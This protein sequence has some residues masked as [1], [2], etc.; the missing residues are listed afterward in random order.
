MRACGNSDKVTIVAA[1]DRLNKTLQF[2]RIC[3]FLAEV[4]DV[5]SHFV[6]LQAKGQPLELSLILFNRATNEG[7]DLLLLRFIVAMFQCELRRE[8]SVVQQSQRNRA[9]APEQFESIPKSEEH[10][11]VSP[12]EAKTEPFPGPM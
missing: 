11:E 7:N 2:C 10:P 6:L 9:N 1:I 8:D 5:N 12:D 4:N 3:R